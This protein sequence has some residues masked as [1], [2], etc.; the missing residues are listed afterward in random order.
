[1]LSPGHDCAFTSFDA[2]GVQPAL[3][4]AYLVWLSRSA[5]STLYPVGAVDSLAAKSG[6]RRK[7]NCL[8]ANTQKK[9][10]YGKD[11]E[12]RHLY[13]NWRGAFINHPSRSARLDAVETRI[14]RGWIGQNHDSIDVTPTHFEVRSE[15]VDMKYRGPVDLKTFECRDI[16]RNRALNSLINVA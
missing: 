12:C 1:M 10:P 9:E 2:V 6:Y 11:P 4:S 15:T 5:H 7:V 16:N 8:T 13:S 14:N 3:I